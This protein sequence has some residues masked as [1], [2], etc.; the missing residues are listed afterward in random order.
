M[1]G[2]DFGNSEGTYAELVKRGV[3]ATAKLNAREKRAVLHDTG[4]TV[5]GR[6]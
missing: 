3:S 1:W 4:R 5:Y 2:S 6:A